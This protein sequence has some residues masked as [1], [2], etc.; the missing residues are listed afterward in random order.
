M[1]LLNK[2]LNKL[3]FSVF[4]IVASLIVQAQQTTSYTYNDAGQ[5]LT[6]DGP[7]TDVID[8]TT[9]TYN[10]QG[11]V[12]TTTN[13]LG[14]TTT[15]N[16]Y[17]ASGNVLSMTDPNGVTTEFTYHDRGWLLSSRIKHPTNNTLDAVTTYGYDA[18]GQLIS[19]TLPNGVSLQYEYDD[20]R[21][22]VAIKN[23]VNERIEYTLDTAGNRTGQVIKN[24]SG[25]ITYSVSSVF[26]ELSRV[27]NVL[28]NNSQ[29]EKHNYDVNN[30]RTATTDGR[31]NQTQQQYDA[32]DR[33]KKIIDPDWGETQFT[34]DARDQIKTVIDARGN[35]TTYNYDG[36]GN[37]TS[38]VSPD[39]G[40]TTFTYDAAGNRLSQTDARGVV[41]NYAYDALNRVKTIKY[42]VSTENISF[43]YDATSST[44]KGV[45]RLTKVSNN[46]ALNFYYDYLGNINQLATSIS[47]V[48]KYVK[49][50]YNTA[51][52]ATQ[53]TYP[54]GRTVNYYYDTQGRIN[55]ITT[56]LGSA[57]IQTLVDAVSY[58]PFGPA[59]SYVYGN[60]LSHTYTYDQDYRL[61]SIQVGGVL[62]RSYGYDPANNILT[63]TNALGSTNNQTY[64]YDAL[65]RLITASGGYGNLGYSYDA[66]GNR[67]SETRN[68][69]TD[70]YT[71]DNNNNR[72]Q[73]ITR[74]SGNRH[75][76]YDAAGNP[77]QR[78]ADDNSTQNFTFNKANRLASVNVNGTLAATYLYNPLGQRSV[79]T[80]ANGNKEIYHYDLN[81][82]LLSVSDGNYVTLREYI[83]WGNQQIAFVNNGAL[84]YIHNDHLNTPQVITNQSQQVVWMGHYEPFGKLTVNA[85]NNIELFSRFPGQYVDPETNLYYNYF[86]DY[87]P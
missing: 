21:R 52:Q 65:N 22:L 34:Y 66:V 17:D 64:S 18:I 11:Y 2:L 45:G 53:I 49:Y 85:T 38:L 28:G 10:S 43:Y 3:L 61:G 40:T 24:S 16:S 12:A 70:T 19:T 42:P 69:A 72:L 25:T 1:K 33:V 15:F 27:M 26:D 73:Q 79:K 23:S 4:F 9:H 13:A 36:L 81:G 14:Q 7:R 32:L 30:N 5:V 67:L 82:N 47:G 86:R 71:Y 83:Y 63:I 80:F 62:N 58:L 75:F 74:S 87:D 8:V 68:G 56:K 50:S 84:Y 39:T 76:T 6:E 78:T 59:N 41:T 37:L 35:V 48:T 31:N 54:S 29:Q 51:G 60:G 20:A 55:K 46:V 77:V 44:N 57:A